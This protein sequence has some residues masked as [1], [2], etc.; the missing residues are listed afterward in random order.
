MLTRATLSLCVLLAACAVDPD[1]DVDAASEVDPAADV[2][3]AGEADPASDAD[4]AGD[5]DSAGDADP[6]SDADSA[7]A[8]GSEDGG[9]SL[10][11]PDG[12]DGQAPISSVDG[13]GCVTLCRWATDASAE[14]GISNPCIDLDSCLGLCA[15]A[16]ATGQGATARREPCDA[17]VAMFA[18]SIWAGARTSC[19]TGD[20]FLYV[21]GG[22]PV[23]QACLMPPRDTLASRVGGIAAALICSRGGAS[24]AEVDVC[25]RALQVLACRC[26]PGSGEATDDGRCALTIDDILGCIDDGGAVDD[27][28]CAPFAATSPESYTPDTPLAGLDCGQRRALCVDAV[29]GQ[30]GVGEY[31][32]CSGGR[33]HGADYH[34][35]VET[36]VATIGA[37]RCRCAATPG[38]EFCSVAVADIQACIAD[39]DYDGCPY[40]GDGSCIAPLVGRGSGL[41]SDVP[42]RDVARATLD[43]WCGWRVCLSGGPGYVPASC[44]EVEH[45]IVPDID[46]CAADLEEV[47][48]PCAVSLADVESCV[49]MMQRNDACHRMSTFGACTHTGDWLPCHLLWPTEC[50]AVRECLADE[51]DAAVARPEP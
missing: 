20:D 26:A 21:M 29:P 7:S 4:P 39:N 16:S 33:D 47:F 10:D 2:D 18:S 30:P 12:V 27:P 14:P 34:S 6:G 49:L 28:R 41:A 48:A 44:L 43:A 45:T 35:P 38:P 42:I 32:V 25:A 13:A 51:W 50:D 17:T 8:A 15:D 3:L 11:L 31:A 46:G 19:A 22:T 23:F 9:A 36:C 1:D 5:V 24:R 37:V 40:L